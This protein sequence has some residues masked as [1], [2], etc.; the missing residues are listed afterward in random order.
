MGYDIY[1]LDTNGR[2]RTGIQD[3][4]YLNALQAASVLDAMTNFGMVTEVELPVWPEPG[5]FSLTRAELYVGEQATP[6]QAARIQQYRTAQADA[7]RWS[8]PD[9][10]GIPRGKLTGPGR[11]ITPSE[12]KAALDTYEAHP[13]YEIA[14]MPVGDVMWMRWTAFLRRAR[15]LG[16][17]RVL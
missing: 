4:F 9:P 7:S 11:I 14:E 6:E 15:D 13:H 2:V 8:E 1:L 16:G 3:S 17:L 5:A 12:V 10:Q